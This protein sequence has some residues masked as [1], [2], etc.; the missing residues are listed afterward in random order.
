MREK[1][2]HSTGTYTGEYELLFYSPVVVSGAS[3]SIVAPVSFTPLVIVSVVVGASTG[4]LSKRKNTTTHTIM[5]ITTAISKFPLLPLLSFM[6]DNDKKLKQAIYTLLVALLQ[7]IEN[8]FLS[9]KSISFVSPSRNTFY[10]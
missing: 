10:Y 2:F 8:Q 7:V 6:K 4:L 1:T 9:Q 3:G 5:A